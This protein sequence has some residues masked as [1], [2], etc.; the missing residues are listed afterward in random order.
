MAHSSAL[1][2]VSV[3]P[4]RPYGQRYQL[5][6]YGT[7]LFFAPGTGIFA[8]LPFI[9]HLSERVKDA[10][11]HTRRI[12]LVWHTDEL[13]DELDPWMTELLK[14][15][16]DDL[17]ILSISIHSTSSLGLRSQKRWTDERIPQL[18][19]RLFLIDDA[20]NIEEYIR[21]E[22]QSPKRKLAVY[23]A[24]DSV[25]IATYASQRTL[26]SGSDVGRQHASV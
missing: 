3:W 12:K 17:M 22:C 11:A 7:V 10:T 14:E 4:D 9:K 5:S 20:P 15:D 24:F 23:L 25:R 19:R 8:V 13:Y 6:D 18:G 2:R 26:R 1:E 21:I 16:S